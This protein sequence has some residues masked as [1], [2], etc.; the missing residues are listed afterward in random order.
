MMAS[1]GHKVP[2]SGNDIRNLIMG[3]SKEVREMYA[4]EMQDALADGELLSLTMDEWTS[5]SNRKYMNVNVHSTNG[6]FWG[7]GLVRVFGSA[8]SE[9]CRKIIKKLLK[10]FNL[11]LDNIASVTTDGARVM[12]K[13][14]REIGPDHQICF[15]HGLHL[16]VCDLLYKKKPKPG[17]PK[18]VEV[19]EVEAADEDDEEDETQGADDLEE[20]FILTTTSLKKEQLTTTSDFA[21]L[22]NKVR[23]V[24]FTFKKSACK[25]DD[26]FKKHLKDGD[27]RTL[28]Y[29]CKTRWNSLV[30][31]IER[32]HD[33]KDTIKKALP[34][35]NEDPLIEFIDRLQS[36]KSRLYFYFLF[37]NI[38]R[39]TDFGEELYQSVLKR[40]LE[41]RTKLPSILQQLHDGGKGKDVDP[42]YPKAS[43][44]QVIDLCKRGMKKRCQMKR[45]QMYKK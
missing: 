39:S 23:S 19:H 27:D 2:K 44:K 24:V 7:L 37:E 21:D 32:F 45:L 28:L 4:K 5:L 18:P 34:H 40:I 16:A 41:R 12:K 15:A 17:K 30:K 25:N 1:D 6:R 9:R 11:N 29:D 35:L 8:P 36:I 31:M 22:I 42:N 33:L 14:G 43:K 13:M 38:D 10:D 3:Y 20:G 26:I